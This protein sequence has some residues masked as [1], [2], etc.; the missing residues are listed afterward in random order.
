MDKIKGTQRPGRWIYQWDKSQLEQWYLVDKMSIADIA[1][2][3]GCASNLPGK[4]MRHFGIP[5]RSDEEG[6]RLAHTQEKFLNK[7]NPE[8]C[9]K[10]HGGRWIDAKGYVYIY[11]PDHHRVTRKCYVQEHILVWEQVHNKQLPDGWIIHH[12]KGIK[13]DNRPE[14]LVAMPKANHGYLHHQEPYK[15]RIREL[16]AKVMLLE[17]TL[18]DSQMIFGIGEN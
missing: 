17:K 5:R 10:W 15:K 4:W 12:L 9:S 14:N 3:I 11:K 1:K 2:K 7:R 6:I 13:G 8:T 16:E 18:R